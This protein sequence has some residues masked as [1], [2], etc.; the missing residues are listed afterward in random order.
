M[1]V[2]NV[3][4]ERFDP[5][6]P[7]HIYCG[8]HTHLFPVKETQPL[9]GNRWVPGVNAKDREEAIQKYEEWLTQQT[10]KSQ[11]LVDWFLSLPDETIFFCHCVPLDCH[12]EAI[13]RVIDRLKK[14]Y[15]LK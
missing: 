13:I 14:G 3:K 8:R 7:L 10:E 5:D 11:R 6:N 4:R 2:A 9:L 1:R 12:S 15:N